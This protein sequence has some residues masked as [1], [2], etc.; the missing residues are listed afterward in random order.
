MDLLKSATSG[1]RATEGSGESRWGWNRWA[2]WQALGL[3]AATVLLPFGWILPLARLAHV[4][5]TL[6]RRSGGH[7]G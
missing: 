2:T 4:R 6:R 5:A 7:S 3:L 1:M